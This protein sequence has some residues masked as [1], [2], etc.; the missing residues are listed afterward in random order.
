V[1]AQTYRHFEIIVVD[2]GSSDTTSE[3]AARYTELRY[4]R[5]SHLGLP[6]ARNAGLAAS[7]GEYIVFLDADDR[8]V[9]D[10]LQ[11]GVN[12]LRAVPDCAFVYGFCQFIDQQGATIPTPPHVAIEENHYRALFKQN[13]IWTPGAAMFRRSILSQ[14]QG[15]DQS[16]TR[17]CEDIE[18]YLRITRYWPIQCHRQ[19]V[20]QYRKHRASMSSKKIKML[21]ASNDVV[22]K[23]RSEIKSDLELKEFCR[24]Y[25]T[26]RHRLVLHYLRINHLANRIGVAVRLR[27]R[28]RAIKLHFQKIRQIR[29]I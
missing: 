20:I 28:V 17:G 21:Y 27:T 2:D 12:A 1:L 4:L 7:K 10:A 26:P 19:V 13:H 5:Q 6:T 3:V 18:L 22:R 24:N 15:F 16:F 11:T 14:V 23:H 9:P 8:L 25:L 29:G